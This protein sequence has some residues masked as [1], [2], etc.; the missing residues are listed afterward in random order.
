MRI[1][2][3]FPFV[4]TFSLS[5][6]IKIFKIQ[7]KRFGAHRRIE[8]EARARTHTHTHTH[9]CTSVKTH[10][11]LCKLRHADILVAAVAYAAAENSPNVR[12][13]SVDSLDFDTQTDEEDYNYKTNWWH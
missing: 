9:T 3:F 2:W 8:Q 6:S 7:F 12:D 13:C 1:D 4:G 5:L 11:D 10:L